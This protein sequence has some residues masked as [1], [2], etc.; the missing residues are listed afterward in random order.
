M[1]PA[2]WIVLGSFFLVTISIGVWA[3][4]R[5]KDSVG[6][7]SP[8]DGLLR[9]LTG[10]SHHVTGY[11][12]AV[13]VAYS[14]I[15]YSMGFTIYVWWALGDL[16]RH[17]LVGAFLIAP[18]WPRMRKKLG[19]LSPTEYLTIRYNVPTQQLIAWSGAP[20]KIFDVA[21]KWTASAILL[22]VFTGVPLT[23]VSPRR[24]CHPHLLHHRRPVGGRA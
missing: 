18:R 1:H 19:I 10:V 3:Y 20:L 7:S 15:A 11:S 21:A 2:D 9:W 13:F 5:V 22:N 6:T 8:P 12:A 14:A 23:P 4:S 16:S 24:R 17:A